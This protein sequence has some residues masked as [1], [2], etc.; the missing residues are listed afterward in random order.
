[1]TRTPDPTPASCSRRFCSGCRSG[2][3]I[4][5]GVPSSAR[6]AT[7]SR[8]MTSDAK[9]RLKE[10]EEENRKL[11]RAVADLTLDMVMLEDVIDGIQ[12]GKV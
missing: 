12:S 3:P 4:T 7:P 5:A 11:K 10:L 2:P 1:M 8:G 6:E 9:K